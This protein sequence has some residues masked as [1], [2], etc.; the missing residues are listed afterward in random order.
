M[1][2]LVR[3]RSGWGKTQLARGAGM[4]VG[5]HFSHQGYFA[6]VAQVTVSADKKVSEQDL[7]AGDIGSQ[8]INPSNALNQAQGSAISHEPR[9]ELGDHDRQGPRGAEQSSTSTSPTRMSKRAAGDSGGFPGDRVL[10][11]GLGE[12][13][14][15]PVIPA[16]CNAISRPRAS[17]CGRCRWRRAAPAGLAEGPA[18]FRD[19]RG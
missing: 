10:A 18:P 4:G 3:E 5:C 8:I 11:D 6:S 19:L 2:E 16:I 7:I 15:P 14:L 9:G 12:P 13:A 17:A 1:L